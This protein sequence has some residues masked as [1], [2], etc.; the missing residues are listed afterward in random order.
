M[1]V[2]PYELQRKRVSQE[3]EATGTQQNE[4]LK[5]QFARQGGGMQGGAYIKAQERLAGQQEQNK[6]KALE[7]VDIQEATAQEAKDESQRNRDFST[8]ERLGSQGFAAGESALGRRFAAEEAGKGRD[9]QS[10]ESALGRAFATSERLGSQ[11]YQTGE[12]EAGQNFASGERRAAQD[13]SQIQR[14]ATQDW[15]QKQFDVQ[16]SQWNRQFASDE[17]TTQFNKI[18]SMKQSGLTPEMYAQWVQEVLTGKY[19]PQ[20]RNAESNSAPIKTPEGSY[21]GGWNDQGAGG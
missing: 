3:T 11:G 8:S 9:W 10:G 16:N 20:S 14:N 5:R 19:K 4:A 18:I 15:Q 1:A 21:N 13:F 17:A 2:N 12:R 7:G 6:Q